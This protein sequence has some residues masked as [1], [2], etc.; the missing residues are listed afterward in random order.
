MAT[1]LIIDAADAVL[2]RI[3]VTCCS[4]AR[5]V[6]EALDEAEPQTKARAPALAMEVCQDA[7]DALLLPLVPDDRLRA[8]LAR[9]FAAAQV[10]EAKAVFAGDEP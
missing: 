9:Y 4:M 6:F 5:E 3:V 10:D 2:A 7:A 1:S 8:E